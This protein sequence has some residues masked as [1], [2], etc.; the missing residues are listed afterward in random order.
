MGFSVRIHDGRRDTNGAPIMKHWVCSREG[1]RDKKYIK[2]T[3]RICEPRAITRVN[4]RTTFTVNLDKK[5]KTWVARSFLPEHSHELAADFETQFLRSHRMVKHFDNALANTLKT[6]GIKTSQIM[7]FFVNQV[8]GYDNL[9]F[10]LKDLYST[11]DNERRSIILETDSEVA[12]AYLNAKADMDPN[13]FSK[14]SVDDKNR[15]ANLFWAF[16]G[17][18]ILT[19]ETVET[20]TRVLETFFFAMNNNKPISI[21]TDGDRAI[22]K[23]IKKFKDFM[24]GNFSPEEFKRWWQ[25]MVNEL[26]LQNNDWVNKIHSKRQRWAEAFLQA[27]QTAQEDLPII[28]FNSQGYPVYPAKHNGHFLW[29]APGSGMCDPNCPCWDDWEEDDAYATIRK[30]KPKKKKQETRVFPYNMNP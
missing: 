30:K 29:D 19:D 11:L 17:C 5:S 6:V 9:G 12:L 8:R 15:L 21:I 26:G 2:R 22:R 14:C 27:V 13:F 23:A 24:L 20:Y 18:A 25:K 7:D 1:E 28:G 4:C 3:N 16:F 10:G